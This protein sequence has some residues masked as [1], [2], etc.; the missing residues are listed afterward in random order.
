MMSETSSSAERFVRIT[1]LASSLVGKVPAS[2]VTRGS[3]RHM[4]HWLSTDAP[5]LVEH[6]DLDL[7]WAAI[8][9]LLEKGI[10]L[11]V[12]QKLVARGNAPGG[13]KVCLL[14]TSPSPRD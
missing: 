5:E 3:L 9:P 7:V 1:N 11:K 13:M 10:G 14:Y 6:D 4:S 2:S 8:E 12:V